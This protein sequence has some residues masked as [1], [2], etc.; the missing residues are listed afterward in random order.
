MKN[1]IKVP[2]SVI[3]AYLF[4]N[5]PAYLFK[6]M[7]NEEFTWHLEK[8]DAAALETAIKRADKDDI[9]SVAVAY[10]AIIAFLQKGMSEEELF[11]ISNN[12]HLYWVRQIAALYRQKVPRTSVT[13]FKIPKLIP[14]KT[15]PAA[16]SSAGFV[17]CKVKPT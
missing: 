10:A 6:K 8:Q 12:V 5:T 2:T 15:E 17:T 3:E 13:T 14:E 9:E 1:D 4:A 16:N 11:S 7:C